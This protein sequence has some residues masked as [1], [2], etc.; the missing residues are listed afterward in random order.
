VLVADFDRLVCPYLPICDPVIA[1]HIVK[2]DKQHLTCE[3]AQYMSD[4]VL[5]YL[6]TNKVLPGE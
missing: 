3:F 5:A 2:I 6:K 1:G 4:D